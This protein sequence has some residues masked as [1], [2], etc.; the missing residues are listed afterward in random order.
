MALIKKINL[1]IGNI[2]ESLVVFKINILTKLCM[3]KNENINILY[4]GAFFI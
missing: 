3:E 2:W 1:I 4:I